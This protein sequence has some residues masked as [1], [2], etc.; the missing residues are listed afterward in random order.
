[1]SQLQPAPK[2]RGWYPDP[3]FP[4]VVRFWDGSRWTGETISGT[5]A[6]TFNN[7]TPTQ[8]MALSASSSGKS[9]PKSSRDFTSPMKYATW[10]YVLAGLSLIIFPLI[11]GPTAIIM[12]IIAR[13]RN[14]AH[15]KGALIFSIAMVCLEFV[16]V[17]LFIMLIMSIEPPSGNYS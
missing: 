17:V 16:L 12:A 2:V 10:A 6:Q 15:S 5:A 11:L 8:Q 3:F 4:G 7:M 13:S 1:M 14:E 9:G